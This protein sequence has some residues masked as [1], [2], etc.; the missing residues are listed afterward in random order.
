MTA[1]RLP[2]HRSIAE[3]PVVQ[4]RGQRA[5]PEDGDERRHVD[6]PVADGGVP[7]R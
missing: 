7:G 4:Q 3:V 1:W 2:T 5:G 6:R